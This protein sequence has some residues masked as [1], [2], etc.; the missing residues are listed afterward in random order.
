MRLGSVSQHQD[1]KATPLSQTDQINNKISHWAPKRKR[2]TFQSILGKTRESLGQ[3]WKLITTK[4]QSKMESWKTN[5]TRIRISSKR[6]LIPILR[7]I[8]LIK[9][10]QKSQI[11]KAN[12]K[13]VQFPNP[14]PEN[15]E[16]KWRYSRIHRRQIRLKE[17][18]ILTLIFPR[19]V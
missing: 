17:P 14:Q 12:Y 16:N 19:S 13:S 5:A 9:M 18:K 1:T 15:Q 3:F 6:T 4:C 10:V 2:S 11:S 7:T 8:L